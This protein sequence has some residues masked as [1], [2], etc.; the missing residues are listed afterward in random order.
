VWI[1]T[2]E[3]NAYDQDG[4]YYV[5]AWINKPTEQDIKT[6]FTQECG[7]YYWDNGKISSLVQHV[8]SGGGRREYETEWYY[9][10]EEGE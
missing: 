10:R 8:L 3:I 4:E 6:I 9:L 7:Y 1:L 2:R 5:K